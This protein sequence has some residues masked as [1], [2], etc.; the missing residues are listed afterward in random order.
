MLPAMVTFVIS[1]ALFVIL[2]VSF[3]IDAIRR[4]ILVLNHK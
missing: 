2:Q 3:G 1:P 4:C